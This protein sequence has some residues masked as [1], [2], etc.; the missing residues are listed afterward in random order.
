MARARELEDAVL[1]QHI[2]VVNFN[3][4]RPAEHNLK[5][6]GRHGR[7]NRKRPGGMR[8]FAS[9]F[10]QQKQ[11]VIAKVILAC[12]NERSMQR[13]QE[14]YFLNSSTRSWYVRP[15][16]STRLTSRPNFRNIMHGYGEL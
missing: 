7:K 9:K 2:H 12:C 10:Y 8:Q 11:K 6:L 16:N 13:K 4:S 5:F 3:L 1:V 15:L 14:C